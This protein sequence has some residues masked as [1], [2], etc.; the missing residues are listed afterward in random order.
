MLCLGSID[1]VDRVKLLVELATPV[2]A[3]IA[4]WVAV[5]AYYRSLKLERAK[6]LKEL[7]E[8]FYE[9]GDLKS[10]RELLD[11]G[12]QAKIVK[13]VGDECAD[14]TDYLNF[15][16]FVAYLWKSKQIS[17]DEVM[18]LFDYYLRNLKQH[19][20]VAKYVAD[21]D[22][23]FERLRELLGMIGQGSGK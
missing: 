12:D 4:A 1:A 14:F 10:V 9:R 16:E 11:G 7:Y 17:L 21:H 13:L 20:E 8:K 6:W 18:G 19:K 3:V 2:A 23:G 22:K 15:F 5:C